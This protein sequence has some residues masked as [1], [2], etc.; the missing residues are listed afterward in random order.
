MFEETAQPGLTE[1]DDCGPDSRGMKAQD[2]VAG[3]NVRAGIPARCRENADPGDPV[4]ALEMRVRLAGFGQFQPGENAARD[5]WG[6]HQ[7][8]LRAMG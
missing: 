7:A 5:G 2:A 4:V 1:R 3:A 8:V 6:F